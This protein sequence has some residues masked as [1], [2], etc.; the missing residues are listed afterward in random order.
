MLQAWED[1]KF[2][3]WPWLNQLGLNPSLKYVSCQEDWNLPW[4]WPYQSQC[5]DVYILTCPTILSDDEL[6][7]E[8]PDQA[9]PSHDTSAQPAWEPLSLSNDTATFCKHIPSSQEYKEMTLPCILWHSSL[10]FHYNS[11]LPPP[12]CHIP[13][14]QNIIPVS[15]PYTRVSALR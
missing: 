12:S 9:S 10:P 6:V 5:T 14:A 8:A 2:W 1:V 13:Y 7:A 4:L 3:T 15:C 11:K